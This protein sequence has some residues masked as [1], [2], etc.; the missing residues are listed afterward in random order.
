MDLSHDNLEAASKR[1]Q[2]TIIAK[3]GHA[4]WQIQLLVAESFAAWI[5]SLLEILIG[6]VGTVIGGDM[7]YKGTCDGVREAKV[8][9]DNYVGETEAY[10]QGIDN[11]Y[12]VTTTDPDQS[13][14]TERETKVLCDQFRQK[15]AD[16]AGVETQGRGVSKD[17]ML[18]PFISSEC[19]EITD[20]NNCLDKI[21]RN[22]KPMNKRSEKEQT[23]AA[24]DP[25]ERDWYDYI[26]KNCDDNT[27]IK[28]HE[29]R[30]KGLVPK[31]SAP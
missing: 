15:L 21:A 27:V 2:Q 30:I 31:P 24:K 9:C 28:Q 7:A 26:K 29:L 19:P 18:A 4:F 11:K 22:A 10:A 1:I 13:L 14:S 23:D 25:G 5:K 8:K 16:W 6:I 20:L 17:S 3:S 12:A